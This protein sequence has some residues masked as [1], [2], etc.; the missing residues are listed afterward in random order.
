[1]CQAWSYILSDKLKW[2]ESLQLP[3]KLGSTL[4]SIL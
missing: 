3:Y 1:M 4:I 2:T